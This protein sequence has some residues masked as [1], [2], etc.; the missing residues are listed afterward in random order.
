MSSN[1]IDPIVSF[2]QAIW[3]FILGI[4]APVSPVAPPAVIPP[5]ENP[6]VLD[7]SD[8]D[9]VWSNG[10]RMNISSISTGS[11]Q[12]GLLSAAFQRSP[13]ICF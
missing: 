5:P 1:I 8:Y 10:T 11:K 6:A 13:N 2:F 3:L 7:L 4:F 12:G 9:L